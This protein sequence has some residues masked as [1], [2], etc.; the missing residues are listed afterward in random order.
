MLPWVTP[1]RQRSR[2]SLT[3]GLLLG[4]LA[5]VLLAL[6]ISWLLGAPPELFTVVV[7]LAIPAMLTLVLFTGAIGI[8]VYD[9]DDLALRICT[10]TILGLVLFT[11]VLGGEL[12]YLEPVTTNRVPNLVLLV[13]VAGGGAVLGFLIGLYDAQQRLLFRNLS[14]EY[15]RT[16]GLSQRLS[17]LA[18]ILRHDL[19]NHLNVIIGHA[20][21][22]QNHAT[23]H[24]ETVATDAIQESG[25]ALV[26]ISDTIHHFSTILSNPRLG[27][28]NKRLDVSDIA[29]DAADAAQEHH[30]IPPDT[31]DVTGPE[32]ATVSASPFLPKAITELI[33]NAIVH[34][35]A[36]NPSIT[37]EIETLD[38]ENTVELRVSDNGPGIPDQELD[39]LSKDIETQLTHSTGVGLWL[40]RWV[41][42]S[43]SGTLDFQTDCSNGTVAC[44][45]LAN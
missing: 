20:E 7:L 29:R 17:V 4:V 44:I 9:L 5:V 2:K 30:D 6:P 36:D 18:R 16:L 40:V 24:E 22:L 8:Y 38:A 1:G 35:D 39:V 15:D 37:V 13:D 26:D 28:T 3:G 14:N 23:T 27:D 33:E 19:R 43:S 25:H 12:L 45:R 31:I 42:A 21:T 34:C 11:I 32:T 41:V 10:W